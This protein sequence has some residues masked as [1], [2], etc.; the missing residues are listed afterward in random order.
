[1][2]TI[3]HVYDAL[4]DYVYMHID[5]VCCLFVNSCLLIVITY[6]FHVFIYVTASKVFKSLILIFL[7]IAYTFPF[8]QYVATLMNIKY[9][10]LC[11]VKSVTFHDNDCII[12]NLLSTDYCIA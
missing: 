10:Y 3:L 12:W 7:K 2:Y 9:V 4:H 5:R 1:M 6:I 11:E 8:F